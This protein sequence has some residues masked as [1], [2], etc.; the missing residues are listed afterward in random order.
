[1]CFSIKEIGTRERGG[2]GVFFSWMHIADVAG[3]HSGLRLRRKKAH[4][5]SH[6]LCTIYP[7]SGNT[8][9]LN[10]NT[11]SLDRNTNTMYPGGNR[12]NKEV[13]NREI[14]KN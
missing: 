6:Q 14:L 8:N 3:G 7:A 13:C 12:N 10:R 11:I 5:T 4:Y 2:M 1:M 9:T